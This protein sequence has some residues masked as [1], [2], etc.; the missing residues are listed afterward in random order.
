MLAERVRTKTAPGSKR[1]RGAARPFFAEAPLIGRATEHI[2][3]VTAYRKVRR[4][5]PQVLAITGEVGI[6]KTRLA[7][8]FL[9]W[10]TAQGADVLQGRAF[11]MGGRLPYQPLVEALRSRVERENAPDTLLNDVWLAELSRLLPE[12]HDRYP[13]LP[14]P[15]ALGE[16]EARNRFFEAIA[17]LCQVLAEQAPLIL[18]IDDLQ[19]ADVASLDMLHYAARRWAESG[20]SILLLLSLRSEQLAATPELSDWLAGLGRELPLTRLVLNPLTAES[21]MQLVHDLGIEEQESETEEAGIVNSQHRFPLEERFGQWLFAE[22]GGQPF[23]IMETLKALFER[24][25]LAS[26]LREDGGWAIDY[27]AFLHQESTLRGFLP[28][29]VREVIRSRLARLSPTTFALL[30]AGAI[31]DHRFSFEYLCRIAGV[32]E[33]EGLPALDELLTSQLLRE[34]DAAGQSPPSAYFFAHDKIRD[35]VYTEA[36]DARRR[37][38]HRRAVE[39][40]QGAATSPAQLAHHA[41]AAGLL[42]PAFRFSVRAGDEALRLFAVHNAIDHYE[43]AQRLVAER[44]SNAALQEDISVSDL[45][46]LYTHLGRAYELTNAWEQARSIYEAMLACAQGS[47][48]S[49][50]ESAALNHLAMLAAQDRLDLERA[51]SLLHQA[52]QVAEQSGEAIGLA[53]TKWNLAQLAHYRSDATAALTYGQQALAIARQLDQQELIARSLN[54]LS[55]AQMLSGRWEEAESAAL[56]ARALYAKLGDR[57]MEA[58]CLCL[59][60]GARINDGQPQAGISSARSAHTISLEIENAWG[61]ARSALYLAQ[62]SLEIG[63]FGEALTFAELTVNLTRTHGIFLLLGFS[64]TILGAVHRARLSLDAARTAHREAMGAI[65]KPGLPQLIELYAAELCADCALAGDWGEA[66]AYA[67]QALNNRGTALYPLKGL[68][69]WYETEALVRAGDIERAEEDVRHFAER[70]GKSRRYRI[71]YLR[72]LAVLAQFR[73]KTA[74]AIL[75]LHEAAILAEEIGLPGELWSISAALGVLY[76]KHGDQSKARTAFVR[77]AEIVQSL[78]NKMED[79]RLRT[80]FLSAQQ[81]QQVLEHGSP[82]Q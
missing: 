50:M 44:A 2:A 64:L 38:F 45:H 82:G 51:K 63:A 27:Q 70:I 53:E 65:E 77:A 49:A 31:L 54:V 9:R 23:F 21:T 56:Q 5:G 72:S 13:D 79:G 32:E 7:S 58:D 37:I 41:M 30:A 35:V 52:L 62:G 19:W 20:A 61:Q 57:A 60:A 16:A 42:A 48:T 75:H 59:A 40:L 28:R 17:L 24:G 47:G 22:T 66:Y 68:T 71:P 1:S 69:H 80:T 12:L 39:V 78:A 81:V 25:L 14:L 29:N 33:N 11:E 15:L 34:H 10:A 76:Q 43:R 8:E 55:Y 4:E 67:V 74:Q 26:S 73:G 46:H 3:L 6:G 18:F 36:G